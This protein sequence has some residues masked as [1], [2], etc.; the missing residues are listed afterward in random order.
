MYYVG[1]ST[2]TLVASLILFQGLNTSDSVTT[3]SLLC[4]FAI[5]FIGVHLLNISRVPEPVLAHN[6]HA[7]HSALENG[8]MN[9]RLSIS[10]RL[11]LDGWNGVGDTRTDGIPLSAGHGRRSS[12]YR[13]Q[14]RTLFSAFG[15]E[16]DE[17]EGRNAAGLQR[18]REEPEEET[19]RE[20]ETDDLSEP[21]ERT[22]LRSGQERR[23][24][25]RG[26]TARH[27]REGSRSHTNSPRISPRGDRS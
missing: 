3:V 17:L 10:G 4:G 23:S 1:F 27:G 16:D 7:G 19:D 5:T 14:S 25:G 15:D 13:H 12:L 6:G 18:L 11:S 22:G 26:R 8:L 21:D 24:N 20:Q 9:P 2:A